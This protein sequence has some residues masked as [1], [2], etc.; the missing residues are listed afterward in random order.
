VTSTFVAGT[1]QVQYIARGKGRGGGRGEEGGGGGGGWGGGGG[2]GESG[3]DEGELGR[4][5]GQGLGTERGEELAESFSFDR[6]RRAGA[7]R[8]QGGREDMVR[9]LQKTRVALDEKL[10]KSGISTCFPGTA[11]GVR[12]TVLKSR[13]S[14][15]W[16]WGEWGG[17]P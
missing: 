6:G 13:E 9:S 1:D 16:R 5:Q 8:E 11:S 17:G 2:R 15:E 3:D 10:N 7:G 14:G 12:M 4:R